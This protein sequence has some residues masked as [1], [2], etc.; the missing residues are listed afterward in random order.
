MVGV[1][2]APA[3][4]FAQLEAL[5]VVALA[6][7]RLVVPALTHLAGERCS[8]PDISTGHVLASRFSLSVRAPG[9]ERRKKRPARRWI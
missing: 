6:L 5:G 9:R 8:D 7:I 1:T 3:A 2:P 4:V